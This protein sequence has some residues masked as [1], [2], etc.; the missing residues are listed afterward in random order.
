MYCLLPACET[1][2]VDIRAAGPGDAI[3]SFPAQLGTDALELVLDEAEPL[4]GEPPLAP[5]TRR[6]RGIAF[7]LDEVRLPPIPVGYRLGDGTEGEASTEAMTLRIVSLLPKDPEQRRLTDIREPWSLDVATEFWVAL[8]VLLAALGALCFHLYRRR[9]PDA[10]VPVAPP[11]APDREALE[12]LDTLGGSGLLSAGRL[13]EYYIR[14]A[15]IAKRYLERRLSAPVLEMTSAETVAYLRA[16]DEARSVA[17]PMRELA[18]AADFIKFAKGV[19]PLEE[20]ERHLSGTRRIVQ[21]LENR[22]RPVDGETEA[23]A[24]PASAR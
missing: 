3:W 20:A 24:A 21:E 4:E 22:L 13:R 7:A 19:S 1:F 23:A 16:H 15:E 8:A 10:D 9:R 12:A 14:L 6:Y 2:F 11:M 5:G 18:G 17:T